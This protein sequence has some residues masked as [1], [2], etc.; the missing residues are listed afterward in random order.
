MALPVGHNLVVT[1]S[2]LEHVGMTLP[3]ALNYRFCRTHELHRSPWCDRRQQLAVLIEF[4]LTEFH[5]LFYV[6]GLMSS[7]TSYIVGLDRATSC[8]HQPRMPE[9]IPRAVHMGFVTEKNGTWTGFLLLVIIAPVPHFYSITYG[10][11]K[12]RPVS[13]RIYR[14]VLVLECSGALCRMDVLTTIV[15]ALSDLLL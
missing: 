1:R 12:N 13:G 14:D 2:S 4:D 6:R 8:R 3:R 7:V 10:G 5:F 11:M 15:A 9:Y